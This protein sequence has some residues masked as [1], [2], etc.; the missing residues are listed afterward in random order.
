MDNN[1]NIEIINALDND[2]LDDKAHVNN[3]LLNEVSDVEDNLSGV[4]NNNIH[5]DVKKKEKAK[6]G[7]RLQIHKPPRI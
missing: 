5:A 1:K 7:D 3:K 6:N 2:S 4:N